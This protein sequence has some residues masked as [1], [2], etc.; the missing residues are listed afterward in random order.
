MQMFTP[1]LIAHKLF[2]RLSEKFLLW[3]WHNY[4]MAYLF[5]RGG[6]RN[7]LPFLWTLQNANSQGSKSR[8]GNGFHM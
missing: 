7:E 5:Y 1:V 8:F 3:Y 6:G 2:H 4:T